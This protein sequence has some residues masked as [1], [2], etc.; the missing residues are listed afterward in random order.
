[1]VK[2]IVRQAM[3]A[4]I[5]CYSHEDNKDRPQQQQTL[6]R[7]RRFVAH[8]EVVAHVVLIL[9]KTTLTVTGH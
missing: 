9:P 4:K 3:Q 8:M 5:D 7:A 6:A 2:E 1:M